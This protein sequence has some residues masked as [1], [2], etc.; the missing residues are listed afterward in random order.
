MPLSCYGVRHNYRG[1]EAQQEIEDVVSQR[2]SVIHGSD[3]TFGDV[4]HCPICQSLKSILLNR[5]FVQPQNPI[6]DKKAEW[7]AAFKRHL[8]E[9]SHVEQR[10][11]S[12]SSFSVQSDSMEDENIGTLLQS[13]ELGLPVLS[14]LELNG[15]G[16]DDAMLIAFIKMA[17][18][19][20]QLFIWNSEM[21]TDVGL[22]FA[23]RRHNLNSLFLVQAPSVTPAGV[24]AV[25]QRC[26]RLQHLSLH[27][28]ELSR[29]REVV[30]AMEAHCNGMI[31]LTLSDASAFTD[32]ALTEITDRSRRLESLNLHNANLLTDQGVLWAA[33]HLDQLK[34]LSLS[35]AR[36]LTDTSVAALLLA[37]PMLRSLSLSGCAGLTDACLR[38]PRL[39]LKDLEQFYISGC[40]SIS[41]QGLSKVLGKAKNLKFFTFIPSPQ[42]VGQAG[43]NYF[44]KQAFAALA[45]NCKNLENL[46]LFQATALTQ[47][48]LENFFKKCPKL[49]DL[50]LY[51]VK[52]PNFAFPSQGGQELLS[53]NLAACDAITDASVERIAAQCPN[54]QKLDLSSCRGITDA[55]MEAVLTAYP[56]LTLFIN[57]CPLIS[58]AMRIRLQDVYGAALV[59][60]PVVAQ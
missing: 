36:E 45:S 49:R 53:L 6:Q 28:D 59:A 42:P 27:N 52:H 33:T 41:G 35:G 54:L 60:A 10:D 1:E 3:D 56:R 22:E 18:R 40:G 5:K 16:C 14:L 20:A 19:F 2:L 11:L 7:K 43:E 4:S 46:V 17:P 9:W 30:A 34:Y 51:G 15:N 23:A 31:S 44:D 39:Q 29:S 55:G 47:E 50:T 21:I 13:N 25:I 24:A 32:A 48:D 58:E 12:L 8:L 26:P 38:S 57:G 37:N